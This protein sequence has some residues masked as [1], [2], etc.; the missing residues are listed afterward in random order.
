M[1][2]SPLVLDIHDPRLHFRKLLADML[3]E[4]TEHLLRI[5]EAVQSEKFIEVAKA[6]QGLG[7]WI[8]QQMQE[9]NRLGAAV[10]REERDITEAVYQGAL[11]LLSPDYLALSD[12]QYGRGSARA[13]AIEEARVIWDDTR[14]AVLTAQAVVRAKHEA[15]AT[16]LVEDFVRTMGAKS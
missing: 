6:N 10:G 11:R 1:S 3:P 8:A 16:A 5:H 4:L 14:K 2:E 13:Y 15:Q 9:A 12:G 7:I